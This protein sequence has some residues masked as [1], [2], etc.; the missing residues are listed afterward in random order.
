MNLDG[1]DRKLI[2]TIK[3]IFMCHH[4]VASKVLMKS[5]NLDDGLMENPLTNNDV[6]NKNDNI[7]INIFL[8]PDLCG[9]GNLDMLSGGTGRRRVWRWTGK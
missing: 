4:F 1:L 2:Y 8:L 7:V 3:Y 5:H 6:D 9:A